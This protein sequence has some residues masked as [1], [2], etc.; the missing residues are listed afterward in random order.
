M[1][2][3]CF[4]CS[5][6]SDVGIVC[7]CFLGVFFVLSDTSTKTSRKKVNNIDSEI[8]KTNLKHP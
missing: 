8:S 6:I 5:L 4:C 2:F 1:D 7:Y 3:P